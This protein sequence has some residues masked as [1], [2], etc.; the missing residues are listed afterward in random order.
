MHSKFCLRCLTLE[1]EIE[2]LQGREKEALL[3]QHQ[4]D[5]YDSIAKEQEEEIKLLVSRIAQITDANDN[6]EVSPIKNLKM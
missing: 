4:L 6:N 5:E 2:R 1:K 3:L